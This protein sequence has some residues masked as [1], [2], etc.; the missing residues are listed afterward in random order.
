VFSFPYGFLPVDLSFPRDDISLQENPCRM[1]LIL[2]GVID[3]LDVLFYEA[4]QQHPAIDKT[5]DLLLY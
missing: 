2:V 5:L 1:L 3:L 4:T